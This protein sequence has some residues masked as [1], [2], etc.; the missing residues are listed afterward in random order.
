M[1]NYRGLVALGGS[2]EVAAPRLEGQGDPIAGVQGWDGPTRP[3]GLGLTSSYWS[4]STK[5]TTSA[6]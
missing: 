4:L 3:P 6:E 5:D 1:S 2:G